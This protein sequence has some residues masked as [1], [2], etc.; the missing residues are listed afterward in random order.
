MHVCVMH[1]TQEYARSIDTLSRVHRVP[2]RCRIEILAPSGTYSMHIRPSIFWSAWYN[3]AEDSAYTSA[4]MHA[5]A[6][7]IFRHAHRSKSRTPYEHAQY[8]SFTVSI[9]SV[10]SGIPTNAFIWPVTPTETLV[11]HLYMIP[12]TCPFAC[13]RCLCSLKE[14]CR[15]RKD[16][17]TAKGISRKRV[18]RA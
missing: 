10:V 18:P 14:V 9:W 1:Y 11:T 15:Q 13:M 17:E 12:W 4:N 6:R 7:M 3:I 16:A 2:V 8:P 5:H